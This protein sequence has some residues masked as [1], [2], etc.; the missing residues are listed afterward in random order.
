MPAMDD[1]ISIIP[2][3]RFKEILFEFKEGE[4]TPKSIREKLVAEE[5]SDKE[6]SLTTE[7]VEWCHTKIRECNKSERIHE[8]LSES[9][10][11]LPKYEPPPR[12][13]ELEARVQRLRFEQENQEY[14]N[15]TR[16]VDASYQRENLGLGEIGK[17]IRTVNQHIISGMQYLLSVVGTFFA[18]FIG[19]GMVT[20][21]Y[22]VRALAA[23]IAAVAVGLAE[24]FFII[25][26]DVKKENK[27]KKE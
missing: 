19:V 13:P 21:D 1:H 2:S 12:S 4:D 8:L 6:M 16:S 26:E 27:I 10:I 20:P 7:E 23:T 3:P 25:R 9:R 22:G 15:M 14:R 18:I 17:D 11:I 5:D 24:L